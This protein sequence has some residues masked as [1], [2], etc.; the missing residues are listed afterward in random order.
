[1]LHSR[2]LVEPGTSI[3]LRHQR[4]VI[5]ARVVWVEGARLGVVS[6]DRVP[7]EDIMVLGEAPALPAVAGAGGERRRCLR[8]DDSRF[9]GRRL[10]FAGVIA[11][12]GILTLGMVT[13]VQSALARPLAAI[14][15]VLGGG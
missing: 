14:S 1:M 7:V 8:P 9:R 11:I 4:H 5:I 6:D 3:E 2:G 10:E 13:T 12:A 15:A